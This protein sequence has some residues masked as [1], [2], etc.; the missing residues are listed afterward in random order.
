MF[1]R[2][3]YMR[4]YNKNHRAEK[5]ES[6]YRNRKKRLQYNG[7]HKNEKSLWA[8]KNRQ[9]LVGYT[10]NKYHSLKLRALG[11]TKRHYIAAG[12]PFLSQ[13]EF[14]LLALSSITY[15]EMYKTWVKANRPL[16]LTP[17]VDR[18]NPLLGYSKGN[19]Q[20]LTYQEN[21]QKGRKTAEVIKEAA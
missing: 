21:H 2:K 5:L 15:I 20:F 17:S 1:N 7:E 10:R 16:Q 19:I 9:T 3:E 6:Y 11:R 12:Q 4:E 13:E 18:I 8:A 14:M